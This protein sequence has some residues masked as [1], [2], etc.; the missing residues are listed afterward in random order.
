M[1]EFCNSELFKKNL[2]WA[3]YDSFHSGYQN[4]GDSLRYTGNI[5]YFTTKKQQ[6]DV[7]EQGIELCPF[8]YFP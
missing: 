7:L 6:G 4:V 8:C 1:A 3:N 5:C 2:S